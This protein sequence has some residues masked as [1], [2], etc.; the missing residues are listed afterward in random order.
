MMSSLA[1]IYAMDLTVAIRPREAGVTSKRLGNSVGPSTVS[2]LD[3]I[4]RNNALIEHEHVGTAGIHAHVQ[5]M[6]V[7]LAEGFD[8]REILDAAAAGR[9]EQR[10]VDPEVVGVTVNEHHRSA[11][12]QCFGF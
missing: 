6:V 12:R 3:E 1:R 4:R 2:V 8:A 11:K 9:G 5:P 10:L 7:V